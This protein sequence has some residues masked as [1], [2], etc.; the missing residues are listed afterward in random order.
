MRH[1]FLDHQSAT[2]L[3]PEAF[4]AMKPF[5]GEAF[6]SPSSLHQ[7]GLRARE[8]V[9]KARAQ[10]ALF[11][12]AQSPEEIIFTS[13][14]AEAANL[15]V[16]GVAFASLRRGNHIVLST[17]EHPAVAGA[18]EFLER[19][20]F[21]CTRVGVDARGVINPDDIRAALTDKTILICAHLANHDIGTIQPIREI[22]DIANERGVAVYVDAAAGAGWLPIDVT[23]DGVS[24]LSFSVHRLG[25]PKGCGVLYR[26][27]R[28]RLENLI[29]G[30]IQEGGKRA[31]TENV[32]SIVGAG[33]AA[34]IVQQR[35][36]VRIAHVSGL[37]KR[38]WNRL[39]KEIDFIQLNGPEL[40]PSRVCNNLNVS[41]EFVEGEG[42]L[43]SLDV[44]GIAVASGTSCVSKAVK[45]SPVLA[46]IGVEH[47]LALGSV[48]LTLGA[49]NT[50]EEMDDAAE[51]FA[52]VTSK[53][54]G[55]SPLW[56]E[57]QA[58]KTQSSIQQNTRV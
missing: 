9:S 28:A 35:M 10:L 27:R 1:I 6:G 43:L 5:F 56:E 20:G 37:Q 51:S 2:P 36:P 33:V 58:G 47:S 39:E 41:A 54:R 45:V 26:N 22:A 25:G 12:N 42:Q 21:T 48:I 52:R 49:D 30:G 4:E 53:L 44:A 11:L 23:A 57:F 8:A 13:S 34:E 19:N 7:H 38:L 3:L 31:G 50:E 16:K 29:H 55:M 40:G 24:L 46:A 17:I 18:I 32:P 14:G 15:A